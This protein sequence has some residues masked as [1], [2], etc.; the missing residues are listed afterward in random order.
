MQAHQHPRLLSDFK[1][2]SSFAYR[3][4]LDHD[5]TVDLR[6]GL[7][8][9]HEFYDA[10]DFRFAILDD[11]RLTMMR[12]LVSDLCSPAVRIGSLWIGTP[13]GNKEALAAFVHDTTRR[14]LFSGC[15]EGLTRRM[16]DNLFYDFLTEARS[17]WSKLFHGAVSGP[18]GSL[19]LAL[20]DKPKIYCTCHK[21]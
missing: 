16:T 6:K 4:K 9:C 19:Y 21:R 13:S 5:C 8:G 15:V 17:P 14:I 20:G 11:D 7:R 1:W 2:H 18:I 12:G 10:R 3:A